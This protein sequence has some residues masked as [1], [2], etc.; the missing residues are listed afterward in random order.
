MSQPI[1][2]QTKRVKVKEGINS[3]V[4]YDNK[5]QFLNRDMKHLLVFFLWFIGFVIILIYSWNK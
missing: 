2:K 3:P 1:K 4:S 5:G